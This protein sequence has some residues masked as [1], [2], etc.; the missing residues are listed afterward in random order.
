MSVLLSRMFIFCRKPS[1]NS[2]SY[3]SVRTSKYN[4]IF[5][6][7][8]V[9]NKAFLKYFC[10][11]NGIHK[12]IISH[13]KQ[14]EFHKS[15]YFL[16]RKLIGKKYCFD[17]DL[18]SNVLTLIGTASITQWISSWLWLWINLELLNWWAE[19][20]GHWYSF[21]FELFIFD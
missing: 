17:T 12:N 3:Q 16:S 15:S 4:L 2:F 1:V 5:F 10:D 13:F 9:T 14:L 18:A 21:L 8:T 11:E 6:L 7:Q 19:W 20:T